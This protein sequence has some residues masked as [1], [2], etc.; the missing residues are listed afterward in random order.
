LTNTLPPTCEQTFSIDHTLSDNQYLFIAVGETARVVIK[1][2]TEGVVVDIYASSG[3][4]P[5]ASTYAFD[6]D[7]A[8]T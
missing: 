3:D 8:N 2:E 5:V 7:L 4:D 1:R 6:S